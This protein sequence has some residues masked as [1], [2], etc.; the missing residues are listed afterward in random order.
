M[1]Y[2]S[3][4]TF[5]EVQWCAQHNEHEW[6]LQRCIDF[7]EKALACCSMVNDGQL[8]LRKQG[9]LWFFLCVDCC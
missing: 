9:L 5:T 8:V 3:R 1:L 7:T 6:E 2:N 4:A